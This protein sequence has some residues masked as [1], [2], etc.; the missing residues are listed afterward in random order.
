[1]NAKLI[2]DGAEKTFAVVFETGEELVA[3]L[4]HFA[5]DQQISAAHLT[6][7]SRGVTVPLLPRQSMLVTA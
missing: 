2:Q 5:T 4:L 1:M 6:G 3:G 7:M